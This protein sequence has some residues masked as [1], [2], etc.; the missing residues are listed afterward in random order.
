M[1]LCT[2]IKCW[3]N[4]SYSDFLLLPILFCP[5]N[6]FLLRPLGDTH[7]VVIQCFALQKS[8]IY[9][10]YIFSD[11]HDMSVELLFYIHLL[12]NPSVLIVGTVLNTESISVCNLSFILSIAVVRAV[13][14]CR[15]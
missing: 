1:L 3:Y 12:K 14:K 7:T 13:N 8:H 15:P 6:S 4:E 10:E 2:F 5:H 9:L 11:L